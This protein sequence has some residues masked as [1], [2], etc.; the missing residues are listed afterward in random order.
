MNKKKGLGRGLG[1]LLKNPVEPTDRFQNIR[2]DDLQPGKYQPRSLMDQSALDELAQSIRQQGLIQPILVRV[3]E[4]GRYEI[5]AGE[6]RWRAAKLAGLPEIPAV[7]REIPDENTAVVALIENIQRE[8]LNPLEEA[9]GLQRL[10][11]EFGMTHESA[12]KAVGKSRSNVSNLLRLLTLAEPVRELLLQGQLDMGH[13]RA[14]LT[15]KADRQIELAK[16]VALKGLSVRE[17]ERLAQAPA[18]SVRTEE[19]KPG[20]EL[21]RQAQAL[22]QRLSAKV[23]IQPTATGGGRVTIESADIG[24]L[25]KRLAHLG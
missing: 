6:R 20:P 11:Q 3:L 10:V 8:N 1:V 9:A 21:S 19:R 13:A 7:V 2:V 24:Q 25:M 4:G 15:L 16:R 22:A 17:T 5:V 18:V 23:S 12:A 14:L